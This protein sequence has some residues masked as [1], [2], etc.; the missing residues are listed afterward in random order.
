M[1][2]VLLLFFI[3]LSIPFAMMGMGIDFSDT[4]IKGVNIQFSYSLAVFPESWMVSEINA[5]GV[6]IAAN[7]ISRT[8]SVMVLGLAKYPDSLLRA[9]LKAVY[10]LKSMSMYDVPFGGT[11]SNDAVYLTNDGIDQGYTDRYIEQTFHHEFSSI[12]FRNHPSF[13]DTVSWKEA[14]IPGFDYNDPEAGVG[15]IRKD[16][17]SQDL[18]TALSSKGFLTQY[19]YSGIENDINTIA[20]NLFKPADGFWDIVN[21]Y[22]RIEKKVSLLVKFYSKIDPMFTKEYFLS[23]K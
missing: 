2:K 9:E 18:D 16:R 11:N 10:F 3:A 1:K 5:K 7:E 21:H 17:S 22:P 13:I 19:A 20:Q 12:L 15:A 23:M 6:A 8:K 4:I 14:N